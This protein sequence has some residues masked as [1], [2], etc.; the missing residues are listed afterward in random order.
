MKPLTKNYLLLIISAL[1]S[2]VPFILYKELRDI[3]EH[4][5]ITFV[6]GLSF[7][8]LLIHIS[9]KINSIVQKISFF[10]ILNLIWIVCFYISLPSYG[11]IVPVCGG[12]SSPIIAKLIFKSTTTDYLLKLL[13]F[14][15]LASTV[16]LIL[17]Y[18]IIYTI[19]HTGFGFAFIIILWQFTT[20]VLLLENKRPS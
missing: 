16:G 9:D 7:S 14:V 4:M 5:F 11:L 10:L 13:L 3:N 2:V 19:E 12:F 17:F 1:I 20:G 18:I 8:F 6:P 15:F